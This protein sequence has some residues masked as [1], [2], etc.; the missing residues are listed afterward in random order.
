MKLDRIQ[1]PRW[2]GSV[3]TFMEDASVYAQDSGLV[4]DTMSAHVEAGRAVTIGDQSF[5]SEKDELQYIV[6][7]ANAGEAIVQIT[8][9]FVGSPEK[10]ISSIMFRTSEPYTLHTR[11]YV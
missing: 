2:K 4:V 5:D 9:T 1:R 8:T 6:N 7:F 10:T 11:G 3:E